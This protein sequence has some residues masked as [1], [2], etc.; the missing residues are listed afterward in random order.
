M[1]C[2]FFARIDI[3]NEEEYKKYLD[4]TDAVF[5]KFKGKYLAMDDAPEA[6]EGN[7]GSGRVVLI[8]FTDE[9][10]L[11]RWYDST[12]YQ[13]ILKHRLTAAD[14]KAMLVHGLPGE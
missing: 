7:A 4:V 6:L 13:G 10:E 14:C 2:F 3:L 12:E 11:R 5:A 1:R 8:E 9:R